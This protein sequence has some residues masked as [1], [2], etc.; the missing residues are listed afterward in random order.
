MKVKEMRPGE[1]S[2]PWC[3]P[4]GSAN[5]MYTKVY[6]KKNTIKSYQRYLHFCVAF[7]ENDLF[8]LRFLQ[9]K[10]PWKDIFSSPAVWAIIV[11]HTCSNWGTYTLLTNIPAY[12]K[13]VLK[14]SI[15]AVSNVN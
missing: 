6:Q 5:E 10:T 2:R 3:P 14:F 15:K 7:V 12:M 9:L 1:G 13:E 11:A 4:F 8:C